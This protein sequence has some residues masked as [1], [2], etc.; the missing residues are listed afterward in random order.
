MSPEQLLD[1]RS[2]DHRADLWSLA[3]V[4]YRAITGELPFKDEDGLGALVLAL[5]TAVYRPRARW[6]RASRRRST[7]GS[8][9]RSSASRRSASPRPKRCP[10]EF[11]AAIGKP[12]PTP[13]RLALVASRPRAAR[14]WPTT[15]RPR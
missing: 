2:V 15:G 8:P 1:A 7:R 9:S 12:T 5:E 6:C 13:R 10:S 14:S 4:V 3:V 11:L